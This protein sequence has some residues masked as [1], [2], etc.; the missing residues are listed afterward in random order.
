MS[1]VSASI[2]PRDEVHILV[3]EADKTG[4]D[5]LAMSDFFGGYVHQLADSIRI[6]SVTTV[7]PSI[8]IADLGI[9]GEVVQRAEV[10]SQGT[11]QL[12]PDFDHL[13]K[14]IRQKLKDGV[15]KIGES[16]QVD[17]N[18]RAVIVDEAG[19]RVK[20]V[21]LKEVSV[22]PGTLE[23]SR[24]ITNQLQMRQIYA[25]LDA[26]QEMQSF[27]IAR[28]RDKDIKV[29]VL[30]AR[31]YILRAQGEN[32][33]DQDRREYLKEASKELLTAENSLYSDMQTATEHMLK[34]T[35]FPIFQRKDQ[36]QS[37]IGFISED[38]QVVTKVA[39]LR[40]QVLD[41]L[42]DTDGAQIEMRQYQSV[43]SDFFSKAL[44]GRGYSA[45]SL[46]HLNYPYTEENRDC[47]FQLSRDLQ[48]ALRLS[49]PEEKEHIYLVSIEEEENVGD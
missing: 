43:M 42:G 19:T 1:E 3:T 48:S 40:M 41:Y 32:C 27:Q 2:I 18:M 15:Y 12:L 11:T 25:K 20:D 5:I 36:I 30:N 44:P 24:S 9:I 45:A 37:Y 16:K 38:I 13:P 22:N 28:A 14:D 33:T 6:N 8:P 26:I 47:W 4:Q 31:N 10:I 21:T 39:G 7:V 23:A 49:Q 29:P 35:R 34:L 17:G 46:I